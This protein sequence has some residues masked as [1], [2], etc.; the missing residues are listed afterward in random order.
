MTMAA[1]L[2]VFSADDYHDQGQVSN[3]LATSAKEAFLVRPAP[4]LRTGEGDGRGRR[5]G[6]GR[7]RC[8]WAGGRGKCRS[9][10]RCR[11]RNSQVAGHGSQ[12]E[13]ASRSQL[14]SKQ[15]SW[16]HIHKGQAQGTR[17]RAQAQAQGRR[18]GHRILAVWDKTRLYEVCR[19]CK[20]VAVGGVVAAATRRL[21]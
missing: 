19:A 15:A 5:T 3:G 16:V 12:S 2:L 11:C 10:S 18:V 7:S 8:G 1:R 9:R 21:I 13:S 4:C 20:R 6:V 17:V 14:K